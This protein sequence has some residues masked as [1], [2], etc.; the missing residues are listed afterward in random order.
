[1]NGQIRGLLYCTKGLGEWLGREKGLGG[2][3]F[4]LEV[5]VN[6]INE[7]LDEHLKK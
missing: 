7:R 4:S 3:L 5:Q 2:M 1:M 6:K